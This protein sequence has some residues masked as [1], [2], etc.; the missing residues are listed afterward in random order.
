MKKILLQSDLNFE[1]V[2][3]S[4]IS[5]QYEYMY[6]KRFPDI[7][8]PLNNKVHT[9][10]LVLDA[11]MNIINMPIEEIHRLQTSKLMTGFQN[12][13]SEAR[14]FLFDKAAE[15][16]MKYSAVYANLPD[17]PETDDLPNLYQK[18]DIKVNISDIK[19]H[20][21]EPYIQAVVDAGIINVDDEGRFKP[22][23]FFTRGQMAVVLARALKLV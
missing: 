10:F 1:T 16:I 9:G 20:V 15:I 3:F 2:S 13:Y 7:I 23:S 8:F 12:R 17:E 22:D 6:E 18:T 14:T 5:T 4:V 19:N 21:Y 11:G